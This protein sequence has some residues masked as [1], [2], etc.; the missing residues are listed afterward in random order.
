MRSSILIFEQRKLGPPG[1]QQDGQDMTWLASENQ[2]LSF[3]R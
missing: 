3:V 2:R 1:E